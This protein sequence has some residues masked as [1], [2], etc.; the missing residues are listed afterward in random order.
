MNNPR[1]KRWKQILI[2]QTIVGLFILLVAGYL[3]VYAMGYKINFTSRKI[4]KTGMIVLSI[5]PVPDHIYLNGKDTGGKEN[6]SFSLE[7]GTYELKVAKEG[8]NDWIMSSKVEAELVNY[9]KYIE[10]FKNDVKLIELTDQ[11]KID[12]LNTPNSSLAENAPKGL[13]NNNYEIWI[14]DKIIARYSTSIDNVSWYPDY[15]HVLFQQGDKIKIIDEFGKNENTL[16]Q[17]DSSTLAKYVLG[18]KSTEIYIYLNS[19]YYYASIQ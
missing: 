10:L 2:G 1:S 7:P 19:K 16:A 17:L 12:Y 4:I 18:A 13:R 9:F 11:K 14:G 15:K 8:Y 6:I 5:N 3:I